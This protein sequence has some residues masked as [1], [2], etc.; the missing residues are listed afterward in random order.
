MNN[1]PTLPCGYNSAGNNFDEV[2]GAGINYPPVSPNWLLSFTA[3]EVI[4]ISPEMMSIFDD[5]CADFIPK[6]WDD[7]VVLSPETRTLPIRG[8]AA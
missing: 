8:K 6:G 2:D 7:T 3:I 5:S 1:H 4:V